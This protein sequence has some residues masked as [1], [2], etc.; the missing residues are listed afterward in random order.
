MII[1]APQK[2][3]RG[4]RVR[5]SALVEVE[6]RPKMTDQLWF[7]LPAEYAEHLTVQ[8]NPFASMLLLPAMRLGERLRVSGDVSPLLAKNLERYQRLF[9]EWFPHIFRPVQVEFERLTVEDLPTAAERFVASTFSGGVDSFHTMLSILSGQVGAVPDY[10]YLIIIHGFDIWLNDTATFSAAERRY[11]RLAEQLGLRLLPVTTNYRELLAVRDVD[12]ELAHGAVLGGIGQLMSPLLSKFYIP[13][14]HEDDKRLPWGSHPDADP[15]LSSEN[16]T[17][18]HHAPT[19]PRIEKTSLVAESPYAHDNLRVC[20]D[21]AAGVNNCCRCSKCLRTML[22]LDIL[23]QLEKFKTFSKPL[24]KSLR[25][26]AMTTDSSVMFGQEILEFARRMNATRYLSDM[27]YAIWRS[28]LTIRL[29]N[30]ISRL[31]RIEGHWSSHFVRHTLFRLQGLMP[32]PKLF[33]RERWHNI[34]SRQNRRQA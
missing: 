12:W 30:A 26:W 9:L 16:L 20:W 19:V 34:F 10:K 14:S 1:H 13:S 33:L 17:I 8:A 11:S 6:S 25:R 3:I 15:L 2:E 31:L 27:T 28:A 4:D 21:N 22:T 32:W 24:P 23:G 29:S 7:E 5:L 18:I